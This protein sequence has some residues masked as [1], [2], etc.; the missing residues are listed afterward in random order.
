VFGVGL[1][2]EW[3]AV[4]S[5]RR[6]TYLERRAESAEN[7]PAQPLAANVEDADDVAESHEHRYRYL[8]RRSYLLSILAAWI[9]TVPVSGLLAAFLA[10]VMVRLPG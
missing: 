9:V 2:R 7:A 5:V 4:H 8:V 1:F 3:Y 10:M 6:R